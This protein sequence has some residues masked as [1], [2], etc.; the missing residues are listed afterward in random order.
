MDVVHHFSEDPTITRFEPHVPK[1]NPSQAPGVWAIDAEHAPLYWFPRDCPRATA[2]PRHA[3]ERGIFEQ[4]LT[5]AAPRLHAIEFAWLERV[6]S[7]TV[8]RYDLD[9]AAFAPWEEAYGQWISRAT[10]EPL[11]VH[12]V[13]N[14]LDAH[15]AAEI[16][17]RILPNLWPLVTLMVDDRWNFSHVRLSNASAARD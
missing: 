9:A 7:A 1:T 4:H 8:Y 13:G 3:E 16:E 11:S 5:T 12:P 17:L 10:V 2:W 14:L 15:A 6:M